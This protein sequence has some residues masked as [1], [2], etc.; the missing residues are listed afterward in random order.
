MK[1]QSQVALEWK[2]IPETQRKRVI[3]L[4]GQ[5]IQRQMQEVTIWG[6]KVNECTAKEKLNTADTL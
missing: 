5:M 3:T 6:I 4:L 1:D 2:K